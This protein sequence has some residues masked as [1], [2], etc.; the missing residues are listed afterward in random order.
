MKKAIQM[1]CVVALIVGTGSAAMA[2]RIIAW[3]DDSFGQVSNVPSG[4]FLSLAS[5]SWHSVAIRRA[6]G[7]GFHFTL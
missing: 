6:S 3:G 4:E 1:V 2:G 5:G 7:S